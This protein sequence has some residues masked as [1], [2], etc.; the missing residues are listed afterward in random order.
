MENTEILSSKRLETARVLPEG[1]SFT[2]AGAAV[3]P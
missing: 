2:A 1:W 3:L